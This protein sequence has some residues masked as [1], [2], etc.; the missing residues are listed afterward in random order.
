MNQSAKYHL[1]QQDLEKI[2]IGACIAL[3]GA[4]LT[5]LA[6]IIPNIDFGLYTPFITALLAILIN[7]IR[8]WLS[9]NE[10]SDPY[11]Q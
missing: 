8:K 3:G 6:Q 9:D 5:Y 11:N 10:P 2:L 7:A 1:N 4:S